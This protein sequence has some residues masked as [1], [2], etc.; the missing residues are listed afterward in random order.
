MP[1]GGKRKLGLQQQAKPE[2]EVSV[3]LLFVWLFSFLCWFHLWPD[4]SC[5][6][7]LSKVDMQYQDVVIEQMGVQ[8]KKQMFG[9]VGLSV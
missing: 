1:P 4:E 6:S 8:S 5:S 3:L 2:N 7:S 9:Y